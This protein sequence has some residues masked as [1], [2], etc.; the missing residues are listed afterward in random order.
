[1]H[2]GMHVIPRAHGPSLLVAGS[3]WHEAVLSIQLRP[4]SISVKGTRL[5]MLTSEQV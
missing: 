1:M 3:G 5:A 4:A 2:V